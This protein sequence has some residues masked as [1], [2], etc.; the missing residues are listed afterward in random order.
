ML[1]LLG[2]IFQH[3]IRIATFRHDGRGLPSARG[4]ALYTLVVVAALSRICRDYIDP[5]GVDLLNSAAACLAYIG[6]MFVL[7][8]PAPMAALLLATLFGNIASTVLYVSG[9]NNPYADAALIVWEVAAL[10]SLLYRLVSR[11]QAEHEK[12]NTEKN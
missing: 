9:V 10:L 5:D 7:I 11:V 4:G 6:L 2:A 12:Q 1:S 3:V 8:R